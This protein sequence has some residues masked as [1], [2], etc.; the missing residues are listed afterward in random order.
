MTVP[1][2]AGAPFPP[3]TATVTV[4]PCTVVT[5]EHEG[6]TVTVG[7]VL[8]TVTAEEVPVAAL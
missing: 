5:L 8:D 3:L 2:D 6:V 7:V 4:N 1:A